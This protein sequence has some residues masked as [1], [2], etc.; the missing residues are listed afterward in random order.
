MTKFHGKWKRKKKNVGSTKDSS[1]N[2]DLNYRMESEAAVQGPEDSEPRVKVESVSSM[3][4]RGHIEGVPVEWKIDTGA[5]STFI[6][7]QTYEMLLDRPVLAPMDS[8]YVTASGDKLECLGRALMHI[9]F[10]DRVF[11]HEVNVGGVRNNLIGEDFITTYRCN[12]DHD[13]ACFVIRG[14]RLPFEGPDRSSRASRVIA[15]E[16]VIVPSRHEAVVKS[17][18]THRKSNHSS[19]SS[20]GVLTPERP[21]LERHGLALAKTLVDTANA[22]VY[23][24]V[25][26][27]GPNDVTVYKHTHM[28][29]FT[30]V[31]RIGPAI[32]LDDVLMNNM[33]VG[34]VSTKSNQQKMPEHMEAVYKRGCEHLTDSQKEEF[35]RFIIANQFCFAGPGEVGRTTL[36]THKIKLKDEKPVREPPRRVPVYKR[37]AL[38]DEVKKLEEKGLIEKSNSPWSSQTVMVQKKDGS[39]RMCIDYRKL[40]E[41]TIKDAYPLTRIDENLDTLEGA[42]WY[43]SLDLDM[44]YHQVP[45]DPDDK[46]KTAFATPRGGLYQYTTMPFGL[47]NAASTFQRLIERTLS[48]LQWKIAVLY[49]DDIVCFGKDFASH[50]SN[51][52]E[53]F[54]KLSKAGLKLKPKKCHL[55]QKEIS[56]LGHVVSREGVRTDPMKISSIKEMPRPK[57][58]TQVRSFLG[59]ASY[60]RKFIENFSKIAKPLFDLTKKDKKF[61]WSEDCENS[62]QELKTRLM[63]APILA[64][65]QVDGSNFIL[66]TDASAYAI[67]AVLSQVQDGK[68]RVIAYGSRCLDKAERNYC[69]TRREMLAVVYFTKYFKHYLLGRK[70]L[71]RTDHGS[72]TW[73]Q[74]FREPDGQIHRWIQQLSQFHM[75]IEHR[76]GIKHGNADAMSRLVTPAGDVCKQCALPWDYNYTG[77]AKSEIKEM[78]EGG[79]E[80]LSDE[81]D[82]ELENPDP[83]KLPDRSPPGQ[84][85]DDAPGGA[86]PVRR[87][88]KPNRPKPARPKKRPEVELDNIEFI[89]QKQEEDDIL[90]E[91]LKLKLDCSEKPKWEEICHESKDLKSYVA[92][93]EQLEV[94]ND[95]LC[96]LWQD[97]VGK[98]KWKICLPKSITNPV[99]WYLH[100]AK[101]AGHQGVKK[102]L[103]KAKMCPFYWQGMRSAVK[104]YVSKCDICGERKHPAFTKRHHLK[105]HVMGA[106][107]ERIATDIAGPFPVTDKGNKY[108]LVVADYFSKLTEVYAIQDIQA[109]TIADT[110]FRNWIKRYGCPMQLHSDQGRQYESLLFQ[111]LCKLLE[112]KKTRTTPLH[113]RSDGMV[114]RMNKT[115]N[116]MLSKYIKPHQRDWDDYLDYIMMV[117]N[118]TPHQ[119]TGITPHHLVY[120]EEMRT[121]LD[122]MTEKLKD[123]GVPEES[124]MATE[125]ADQLEE[126]LRKAH[127]FARENLGVEAKRQKSVYD[128]NV[129]SKTYK[130]G[131]LV[132]RNQKKN[133]PGKKAKIARQWTGQWIIVDK[134]SDIIFAIKCS[135]NVDAVTVHGDNLKPYTGDKKFNWFTTPATITGNADLAEFPILTDY[136]INHDKSQET[137]GKDAELDQA[138]PSDLEATSNETPEVCPTTLKIY[139]ESDAR[140]RPPISDD[141]ELRKNYA[142]RRVRKI[143]NKFNDFVLDVGLSVICAEKGRMPKECPDCG[144]S[145]CNRRNMERHYNAEHSTK[146]RLLLCPVPECNRYFYR[147]EYVHVHLRCTHGHSE[148]EAREISR[149][150]SFV[151]MCRTMLDPVRGVV[152]N[153]DCS[154]SK[155]PNSQS[156]RTVNTERGNISV[157]V[158]AESEPSGSSRANSPRNTTSSEQGKKNSPIEVGSVDST[159]TEGT[160]AGP[161][162][163]KDT[164]VDTDVEIISITLIKKT[165]RDEDG[166]ESVEREQRWQASHHFDF[167]KFDWMTFVTHMAD[168]TFSHLEE[169]R[170]S[171]STARIVDSS[172]ESDMEEA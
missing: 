97:G 127:R 79:V 51:L 14:S 29:I 35:G 39:W 110:M 84:D 11:E 2:E 89:R 87:G 86:S 67:G 122:L 168:E 13:E 167:S 48:G 76:P 150:S 34:E 149:S 90:K 133:V 83:T 104:T 59:L 163:T 145:F 95:L 164:R 65:P 113:P 19:S 166:Q 57:T 47:C 100:D 136:A 109:E 135:K 124:Q 125:Y 28:A 60:Y 32:E 10:G 172:D 146:V 156:P 115:V 160:S 101:T 132:Y 62:F 126:N 61:I 105:S 63:S 123:N 162:S 15:L 46:E 54:E 111:E 12:W 151:Q 96:L 49:L 103:E 128:R 7:K 33:G 41:R 26:N 56:F 141:L 161:S 134:I 107:F 170:K 1:S 169:V 72:L 130:V 74:R 85:E 148:T 66:D 71:I 142:H 98:P 69:V 99:L 153:M 140:L 120:G 171:P 155:V 31:Q 52:K 9:T 157:T 138:P 50:L 121:P 70:F 114:E 106:P 18:L 81:S 152:R 144:K 3:V 73:L 129:R 77:P 16:T 159:T 25:Y 154:D 5:K 20:V 131:D 53:V 4:V 40:N 91:I 112:V 58:V 24:R 108:I 88:R 68:E 27:P 119:S 8:N 44:A 42:E 37:Q 116:D 78:K 92:K 6:T 30:P 165:T 137:R 147:R 118:S 143:P 139:P 102:T 94:K 17:G 75:E 36:A 80:M 22:T 82:T 158:N 64:F 117:Y 38:E 55:M 93:W 23:T 45:M 21:F 43:S